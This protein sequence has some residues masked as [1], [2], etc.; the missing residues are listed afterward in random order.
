MKWCAKLFRCVLLFF[1]VLVKFQGH[2][3][4]KIADFDLNWA[5]PDCNPNLN[6]PMDTRWCTKLEVAQNGWPIV[7]EGH[8]S[9][10]KV[11]E[12]QTSSILS[13]IGHFRSVTPVWIHWWLWNAAQRLKQHRR[14]ALLVFK[15]I[16]Q[17]SNWAFPI[18]TQVWNHRC[19]LNVAQRLM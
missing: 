3:G 11:T 16:N 5:F 12:D 14:G 13:R 6:S 7:F 15:V 1:K 17:I 19:F 2:T 18:V 4:H 8:P 9:N 10:F